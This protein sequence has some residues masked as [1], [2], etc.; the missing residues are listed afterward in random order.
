M[1]ATSQIN[2]SQPTPFSAIQQQTGIA[3]H[4]WNYLDLYL[5][6]LMQPVPQIYFRRNS[7][8]NLKNG[9]ELYIPNKLLLEYLDNFVGP[10]NYT[11]KV[12]S[13]TDTNNGVVCVV[14]LAIHCKDKTVAHQSSAFEPYEK[15]VTNYKTQQKEL[16]PNNG[17]GGPSAKAEAAALRGAAL[18]HGIDRARKIQ[19]DDKNA[20]QQ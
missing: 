2:Q 8:K 5:K 13:V 19:T 7:D 1:V 3:T 14:E 17:F 6:V 10:G 15:L 12:V 4:P 20:K 18:V 11:K 9:A 16:K